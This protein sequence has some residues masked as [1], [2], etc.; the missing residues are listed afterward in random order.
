MKN[1]VPSHIAIIMDGNG[2]WA[3]NQGFKTRIRGHEV[4]VDALRNAAKYA[5]KIGVKF[6]TVYA[7]SQ[8]NWR[9]PKTEVDALMSIL[10]SSL[11]NEVQTLQENG[12]QL[13][14]IGNKESLPKKC[15]TELN[16]AIQATASNNK[17][18]L[19]LALS[20]SSRQEITSATK[21]IAKKIINGEISIDEINENMFSD[22]LSTSKM[23]DPELLIRTSGEKRI[24]NFLLWQIS[25]T[26]L[27]FL[28]VLWPDFS[29]EH[30]EEAILEFNNRQ[31]R[32]GMTSE[33]IVKQY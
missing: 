12:I 11:N 6:L 19:T 18:T 8:E 20:Y 25:Y 10:V 17:M 28:N 26:E 21:T 7:F 30:F 15:R 5:S 23:P 33:Q 24:S 2:R 13:N 9:R 22:E 4:G 27:V 29:D 1:L 32:L 16:E 14:A 31:R 3:K